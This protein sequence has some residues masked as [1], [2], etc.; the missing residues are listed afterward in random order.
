MKYRMWWSSFTFSLSSIWSGLVWLSYL[1]FPILK[2]GPSYYNC[3]FFDNFYWKQ[4]YLSIKYNW[5][6][7]KRKNPRILYCRPMFTQLTEMKTNFLQRFVMENVN[8]LFSFGST[9]T[10][11][12]II[13][14][15]IKGTVM[16]L[17]ILAVY[18]NPTS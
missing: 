9:R 8:F 18:W 3:N 7:W 5:N 16:S 1:E 11:C 10:S 14:I 6:W 15:I 17:F 4:T 2:F 12:T 13:Y